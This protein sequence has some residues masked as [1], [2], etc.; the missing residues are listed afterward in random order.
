VPHFGPIGRR[1]LIAN[2]RRLGFSGPY[3]GGR[4]EFMVKG[5]QTPII[6]NPHRGDISR[7]LLVRIL[8]E[9]GVTRDEWEAL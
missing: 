8:Q 5:D 2:L 6:P 9:A 1:A 4:H 7:D 3:P